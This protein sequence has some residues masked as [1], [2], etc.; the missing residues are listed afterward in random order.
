MYSIALNRRPLVGRRGTLVEASPGFSN[1]AIDFGIVPSGSGFGALHPFVDAVQSLTLTL[2]SRALT[3]VR[4][5]FP[6]VRRLLAVVC[7]LIPLIG[8]AF[9]FV[10]NSLAPV[11]FM[12]APGETPLAIIQLRKVPSEFT[13]ST[14]AFLTDHDLP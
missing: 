12:L 8:E 1:R 6:A 9:S 3:F 10:G 7:D 14:G 4:T 11:E 13:R 5:Q 2:R